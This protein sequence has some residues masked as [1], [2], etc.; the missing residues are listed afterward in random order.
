[1][2]YS[3]QVATDSNKR[4][5]MKEANV[6]VFAKQ[7]HEIGDALMD[8]SEYIEDHQIVIS[9]IAGISIE[10][11]QKNIGKDVAVIRTMPN[12]SAM[13]G[14]SATA[15]AKGKFATDDHLALT[16]KMFEAIVT[17]SIVEED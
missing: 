9:L 2:N 11:I 17:V 4:E 1:M 7:P 5:A 12:T 3:Y 15:I 10:F 8:I 13:I 16:K 14:Y 6:V